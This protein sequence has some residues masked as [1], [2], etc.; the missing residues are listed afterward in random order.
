MRRYA[1][2]LMLALVFTL[3]WENVAELPGIGR[4]SRLVGLLLAVTWVLAVIESGWVRA[5]RV[6]HARDAS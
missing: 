4:V 1:Y 2:W 5:P 3:P 6:S